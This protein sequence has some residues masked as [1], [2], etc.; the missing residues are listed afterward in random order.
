MADTWYALANP[1]D[2]SVRYGRTSDYLTALNLAQAIATKAV[3]EKTNRHVVVLQM[4]E[5]QV[6]AMLRALDSSSS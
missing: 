4:P 5:G 2:H 6:L 1:K 3:I